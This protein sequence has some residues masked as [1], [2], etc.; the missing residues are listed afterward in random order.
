MPK[1]IFERDLK[2]IYLAEERTNQE[3]GVGAPRLEF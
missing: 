3:I 1:Q 2:I